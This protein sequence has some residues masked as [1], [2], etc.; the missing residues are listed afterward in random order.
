MYVKYHIESNNR[1]HQADMLK[2]AADSDRSTIG[3]QQE[4]NICFTK[5]QKDAY[6]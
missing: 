3:Y 4:I 2:Y 1:R 5:I 6:A